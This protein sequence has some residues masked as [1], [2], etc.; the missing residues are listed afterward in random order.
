VVGISRMKC[1]AFVRC[2]LLFRRGTGECDVAPRRRRNY[3]YALGPNRKP[4]WIFAMQMYV[5][6]NMC[7][8]VCRNRCA[9]VIDEG[10]DVN[11][12]A[13]ANNCDVSC[14]HI[15]HCADTAC[16]A[17]KCFLKRNNYANIQ[18]RSV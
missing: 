2:L 3:V 1:S 4:H 17:R 12:R 13:I 16:V 10:D 6:Y 18:K 9:D 8:F 15:R 11:A 7:T 5:Y 14:H